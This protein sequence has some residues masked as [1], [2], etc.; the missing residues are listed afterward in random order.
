M[1]YSGTKVTRNGPCSTHTK[2]Y[3][4]FYGG[5]IKN[6]RCKT[7]AELADTVIVGNIIYDNLKAGLATVSA[8]KSVAR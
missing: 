7:M 4:L 1:E 5:G 8:V 3:K 2:E 6:A